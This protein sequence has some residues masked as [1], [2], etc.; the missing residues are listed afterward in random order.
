M[1]ARAALLM[2]S[3]AS[4]TYLSV[5]PLQP[6]A[7]SQVAFCPPTK[8][9]STG[10]S[11]EACA[12]E[13]SRWPNLQLTESGSSWTSSLRKSA[14][15]TLRGQSDRDEAAHLVRPEE[16]SAAFLPL[17][18][19]MQIRSYSAFSPYDH[20]NQTLSVSLSTPST[21]SATRR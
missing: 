1:V 6:Y 13:A 7:P 2:P 11:S 16:E 21:G 12:Y 4:R 8:V 20:S 10:E 19:V 9:I 3:N 17:T 14:R 5:G 15:C 18:L